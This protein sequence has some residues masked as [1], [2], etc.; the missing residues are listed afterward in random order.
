MELQPDLKYLYTEWLEEEYNRRLQLG[1]RNAMTWFRA[2]RSL[3]QCPFALQHPRKLGELKYIGDK[4]VRSMTTKLEKYCSENGYKF[5]E[6]DKPPEESTPTAGQHDETST[7]PKKKKRKTSKRRYV[8]A[9]NT[10]GY[11]ILLVLYT[12]DGD[13]NGMTKNEIIRKVTPFCSASFKSNPS[14]G[15]FYS[16]WNSVNTLLKNEYVECHGRPVYYYLTDKGEE[17]AKVLKEVDDS[18]VSRPKLVIDSS[19]VSKKKEPE[20]PEN[21]SHT[22]SRTVSS[23]GMQ[24]YHGVNYRVWS[25]GSYRVVFVSDNREVRSKEERGFFAEHLRAQGIKCEVE[26]LSVGDGLWAAINKETN[27]WATLDFIFERKRLDDLVGSI[28]DGRFREQESRLQKT[29]LK[30]IMYLIEEQMSSDVSRF[31]ESLQTSMAMAITYSNFHLMRTKDSDDTVRL[32]KRADGRIQ[33]YYRDK[34]LVVLEPRNLDSQEQ[35]HQVLEEFRSRFSRS[36]RSVVYNYDTFQGVMS[37]SKMAT[38]AE[39]FVRMLMTI[40]GVSLDKAV[41]IQERYHT[42]VQLTEAYRGKSDS[43]GETMLRREFKGQIGARK[44]GPSLS[45]KI[46]EVWAKRNT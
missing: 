37:K 31:S 10:G 6:D 29:G 32:L 5:P 15:Q 35:Y 46:Y 28:H 43:E 27:Q 17:V 38:V 9:K 36:D 7:K 13:R 25:P 24:C 20:E 42:P 16:A 26:P 3:K 22:P 12:Q 45:K 23:S 19:P 30:R 11:G 39:M 1:Q 2:L 44:I 8:P 18:G 14:T 40:R 21:I 4:I 33:R 34:T 41:A